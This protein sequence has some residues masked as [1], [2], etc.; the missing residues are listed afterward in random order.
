MAIFPFLMHRF[1][2]NIFN[3]MNDYENICLCALNTIFG[4]EPRIALALI[5]FAGSASAVF[6]LPEDGKDL[7]LGNYSK[8]RMRL[9][10]E[11]LDKAALVL[12]RAASSG[13]EFVGITSADYPVRLKQ[14]PD[15]P[16]GLFVR[17]KD[18]PG[19]VFSAGHSVAV[20]GTRDLSPYGETVCRELV[21]K[22]SCSGTPPC[23]VSGLALG[24][25]IV[26]HTEALECGLPCIAVMATG[27]DDVYPR[28]HRN[29]AERMV[30][31]PGSALVTDYPPGTAPLALN[32]LRRNRIIA[33]LSDSVILVESAARGGG[34]ATCRQAF[35]YD[36]SVYVLPGR[37]GDI[38]S[39]GC[40]LLLREGIAEIVNS[41]DDLNGRLGLGADVLRRSAR[42]LEDRYSGTLPQEKLGM[43][44]KILDLVRARPGTAV[45]QLSSALECPFQR[46]SELVNLLEADG[47]IR[48]DLL[49]RCTL[50]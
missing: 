18:G 5:E 7:I 3:I 16:V 28:R 46:V 29:F 21:R 45:E 42:R 37:L 17:S 14:C 48:I 10:Q 4:Y 20:V 33:G 50:I 24:V 6:S 15:A 27:P 25:D 19:T 32:F 39:E 8:Y 9:C 34:M 2:G 26:A 49:R 13:A 23:I 22:L 31:C 44:G 41:L 40:N 30:T 35:S 47:F 43:M 11:E 36:R 1:G 12:G 38:H